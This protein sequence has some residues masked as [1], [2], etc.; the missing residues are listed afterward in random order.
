M[1]THCQNN[2]LVFSDPEGNIPITSLIL[3]GSAVLGGLAALHTL[4]CQRSAG[5]NW[6][7]S[8][9]R[10]IGAGLSFFN[11]IYTLEMTAYYYY[12]INCLLNA[13]IPVTHIG[14]VEN[15]LQKATDLANESVDGYG[16][17]A[18]TKKTHGV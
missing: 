2:P 9:L 3:I 16:S 8:I 11:T 1:F 12:Y 5:I 18:G 17:V 10:S 15:D 7:D 4:Y 14:N 6:C 13:E